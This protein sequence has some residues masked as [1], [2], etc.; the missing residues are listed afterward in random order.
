MGHIPF[1]QL[2][3][4]ES[5]PVRFLRGYRK[6]WVGWDTETCQGDVG[7]ICASPEPIEQDHWEKI[8]RKHHEAYENQYYTDWIPNRDLVIYQPR[9]VVNAHEILEA[10]F[11]P[12]F[13]GCW[14]NI[15]YD[16]ECI[17]KQLPEN[18]VR[19]LL[20]GQDAPLSPYLLSYIPGKKF[21]IRRGNET[22]HH[23]DFS[24][25]YH[26]TLDYAA[27]NYLDDSKKN[28]EI[29]VSLIGQSWDHWTDK[30]KLIEYCIHDAYLTRKLGTLWIEWAKDFGIDASYPISPANVAG[31]H[32]LKQGWPN[33]SQKLHKHVGKAAYAAYYA[34]RFEARIKGWHDQLYL[35]DIKSAYP[36]VMINL[37]DS[38]LPW[39]RTSIERKAAQHNWGFVEADLSVS[40]EAEW[41]PIMERTSDGLVYSPVGYIGKKWITLDEYKVC[42]KDPNT[43]I[44]FVKAWLGPDDGSRPM[45][46]V[47][48]IYK[49]RA[50]LKANDDPRELVLKIIMNSVYGKT[51]QKTELQQAVHLEEFDGNLSK[52]YDV[53]MIE[54]KPYK[55]KKDE[56]SIGPLFN[57]MYASTIT[58]R[59]RCQL[60]EI[61]QQYDTAIVMTDGL[62]TTEPLDSSIYGNK[63]GDWEKA[64]E[65]EGIIIGNGMYQ[66]VD[67]EPKT[68]GFGVAQRFWNWI[69]ALKEIAADATELLVDYRRPLHPGEVMRSNTYDLTDIGAF[70]DM[71]RRINLNADRKR[72]FPKV[73]AGEM[74]KDNFIGRCI[75]K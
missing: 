39:E 21:T 71:P 43:K 61:M 33:Y 12:G 65:G 32:A 20:L 1:Q 23:F 19:T 38:S 57:P 4:R 6:P 28:S 64:G 69:D 40:K 67:K 52:N 73:T 45:A 50:K 48:D 62:L 56:Y 59:C 5:R 41:S 13:H 31:K 72:D 18:T 36:S 75:T 44:D 46:W 16:I 8:G 27:K 58:A 35:S 34:G 30:E 3:W 11:H 9:E 7:L 17:I 47:E 55:I 25:F 68:R 42:K 14:W 74:L 60:W 2:V 26:T 66:L 22:C 15:K 53:I 49:E 70:K 37:P 51:I 24:H 29:D 10:M 54:G 63:L